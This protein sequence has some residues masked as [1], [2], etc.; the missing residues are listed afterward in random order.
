M[1]YILFLVILISTTLFPQETRH[2]SIQKN[3]QGG[4]DIIRNGEL[5]YEYTNKNSDSSTLSTLNNIYFE[6]TKDSSLSTGIN[7][8]N[9]PP[10]ASTDYTGAIIAVAVVF[11]SYMTARF[12][13]N[14]QVRAENKRAWLEK[15]RIEG[16]R[17]LYISDFL[18]TVSDRNN[19]IK[20]RLETIKSSTTEEKTQV[21]LLTQKTV[22]EN[23]L[24]EQLEIE[25]HAEELENEFRESF[26]RFRFLFNPKSHG[27][28]LKSWINFSASYREEQKIAK[29]KFSEF[30]E[31]M[32]DL[33]NTEQDKLDK[34]KF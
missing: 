13:Y 27:L 25:K 23:I 16:A 7:I 2:I 4:F 8:S 5:I 1:K 6:A 31:A 28:F 24:K 10:E 22:L 33:I 9:V 3:N 19:D 11:F 29:E 14:R 12:L 30:S 34:G 20:E 32:A 18:I 26:H 17:M 15:V 21:E